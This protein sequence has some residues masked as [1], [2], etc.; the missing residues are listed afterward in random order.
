MT[1]AASRRTAD[2]GTYLVLVLFSL[3]ILLPIIWTFRVS[4]LPE[5][6]AYT[7]PPKLLTGFS[8][9]NYR[10][11]LVDMN[12]LFFLKN[13]LIISVLA[14]LISVPISTLGG[15]AFARYGIG[16]NLLKFAVL[17]TQM[18]PG[19]ILVLP[20][21]VVF[22]N[23]RLTDSFFGLTIA[24]MT[25]NI[26]FLVWMLIGFFEGIPRELEEAAALDGLSPMKAFFKI[27]VPVATPGILA[28]A[29]LSFI[30][31]WNE[32]L[33]ALILSG[34]ET[35]TAPVRLA[36]MKTKQ[37]I[38]IGRLSAGVILAISPMLV[39]SPFVKKYLIS[40][41]TLGSVK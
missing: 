14:T 10:A 34:G 40:G 35:T 2:I 18:L 29:V 8:F 16:G 6:E 30:F 32:F 24:Y 11:L 38:L 37:G 36:A 31:C 41:L 23:L 15:F 27:I 19:I 3:A 21:F 17:G 7:I 20:I 28:A 4:M 39:I 9:E 33:F 13:S 12:F 26:P 1:N 25:F 22:N 5:V